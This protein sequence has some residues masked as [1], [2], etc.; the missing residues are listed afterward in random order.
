[1]IQLLGN[2]QEV[3]RMRNESQFNYEQL[4][5]SAS[6]VTISDCQDLFDFAKLLFE[7]QKYESKCEIKWRV[8]DTIFDI[9]QFFFADAHHYFYML[10]EILGT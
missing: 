9:I 3:A 6:K 5:K 10:K 1:M 4:S 7:C 2:R 8:W